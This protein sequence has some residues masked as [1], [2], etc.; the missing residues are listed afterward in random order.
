MN[1]IIT[2]QSTVQFDKRDSAISQATSI[3]NMLKDLGVKEAGNYTTAITEILT[4]V[5]PQTGA[6]ANEWK[7]DL[8]AEGG[9]PG[10]I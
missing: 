7:L 6:A 1:P 2:V 10:G 4:E 5:L 3:V 9:A 8:N